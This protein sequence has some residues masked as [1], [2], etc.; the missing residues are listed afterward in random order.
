MHVAKRLDGHARPD[1]AGVDQVAFVVKVA[2]QQ[3]AEGMS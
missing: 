2:E 3:R 1:A